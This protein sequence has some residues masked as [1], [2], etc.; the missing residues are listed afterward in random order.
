MDAHPVECC[1]I[2]YNHD[3]QAMQFGTQGKMY[4]RHRPMPGKPGDQR[5]ELVGGLDRLLENGY[6]ARQWV[7]GAEPPLAAAPIPA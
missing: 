4:G 5:R 2:A 1:K 7:S 3:V 6:R